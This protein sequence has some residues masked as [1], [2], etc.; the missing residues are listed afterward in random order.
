MIL[1][2]HANQGRDFF[3]G[4]M[5][6]RLTGDVCTTDPADPE[7]AHCADW[8]AHG[9]ICPECM[10]EDGA[11]TRLLR[12]A[13]GQ[14]ACPICQTRWQTDAALVGSMSDALEQMAQGAPLPMAGAAAYGAA[15]AA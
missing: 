14:W 6:C 9:H 4:L 7:P 13:A 12:N 5:I 15:P 2:P 11:I 3:H 1:C 8:R 10:T